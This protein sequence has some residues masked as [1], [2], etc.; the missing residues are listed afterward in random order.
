MP[1]LAAMLSAIYG[2][3]DRLDAALFAGP[4]QR[5]ALGMAVH[6]NTIAHARRQ[7]LADS[8]PRL[9]TVIGSERFD[10]AAWAYIE[11]PEAR[12]RPLADIGADFPQWLEGS[13]G[14]PDLVG[15]ATAEWLW[16]ESYRAADAAAATLAALADLDEPAL[17]A[18]RFA[19]HPAARLHRQAC[20]SA[21]VVAG[22]WPDE[23]PMPPPDSVMITRPEGQV[24]LHRAERDTAIW[25]ARID[26]QRPL[27][28]HLADPRIIAQTDPMAALITLITAGALVI[29]D[30][31]EGVAT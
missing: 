27:A 4:M 3:P 31:E 19:R 30:P 15:L 11:T 18:L 17:M 28:Q 26:G 29:L 10:H 21:T 7:A 20:W 16:L 2:G 13:G 5:V 1:E 8:F 9:L 25:F 22:L 6:A 23:A 12:R 14:S 24:Q